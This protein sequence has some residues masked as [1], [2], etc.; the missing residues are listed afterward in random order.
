MENLAEVREKR[1]EQATLMTNIFDM[2]GTDPIVQVLK[3][4]NLMIGELRKENDT[5]ETGMLG[6]NQG[7]IAA[8]KL[9][10]EAI[11]NGPAILGPRKKTN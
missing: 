9:L 8:Y 3:F 6:F 4:C 5:I 1:A 2:R 7:R 10:V 11:T